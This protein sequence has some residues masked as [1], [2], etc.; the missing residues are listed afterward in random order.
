MPASAVERD[1]GMRAG[2]DLRADLREMQGHRLDVDVG[3]DQR[4]PNPTGGTDGTKDVGPF[5]S[6]I[7]R[8]AGTAAGLRPDIGQAAL[9]ADPGFVLP[10]ELDRLPAGVLGNGRRDEGGEVFLCASCAAASC[11][12]WRGRVE[13]WLKFRRASSLPTDRSCMCTPNAAAISSRKSIN[14]QRTTLWRSASGP[15]RTHSA[16]RCSCSAA[17]FR[18]GA[19]G[20][21]RFFRPSKPF[22]L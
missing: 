15:W 14:R 3:Q 16:T 11:A 4:R 10:P 13:T 8:L 1:H 12:G 20:L 5:V 22:A 2:G 9:L 6:L 21:G 19:P 17:N 7:A 18:G